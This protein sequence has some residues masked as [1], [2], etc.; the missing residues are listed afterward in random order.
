MEMF[1]LGVHLWMSIAFAT[2]TDCITK[3]YKMAIAKEMFN[4]R[5]IFWRRTPKQVRESALAEGYDK[6]R[7][8]LICDDCQAYKYLYNQFYDR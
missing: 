1:V 7:K 2:F 5:L 3:Q 8:I 4:R 6:S